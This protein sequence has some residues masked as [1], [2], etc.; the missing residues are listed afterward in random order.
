MNYK[1]KLVLCSRVKRKIIK[2]WI[3]FLDNNSSFTAQ[4]HQNKL[5]KVVYYSLNNS[6]NVK[7]K[8]SVSSKS[9]CFPSRLLR[10][11]CS[12]ICLILIGCS[13]NEF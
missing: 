12:I 1:D 13:K 11:L 7:H 9:S 2:N 4:S 8:R 5:H 10:G 3:S 6:K